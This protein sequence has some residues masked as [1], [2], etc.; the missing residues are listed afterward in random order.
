MPCIAQSLVKSKELFETGVNITIG[1]ENLVCKDVS[2][3]GMDE[4]DAGIVAGDMEVAVG[5][6]KEAAGESGEM[7]ECFG[8]GEFE[9]REKIRV[10]LARRLG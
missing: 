3:F 9:E 8:E 1:S 10:C 2:S 4:I 7:G 6:G 5:F